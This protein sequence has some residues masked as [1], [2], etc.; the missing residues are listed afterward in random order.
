MDHLKRAALLPASELR[1]FHIAE[2][3]DRH[4]GWVPTRCR[5]AITQVQRPYTSRRRRFRVFLC[6]EFIASI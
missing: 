3:I 1:P 6:Q 5:N 2:W 4:P